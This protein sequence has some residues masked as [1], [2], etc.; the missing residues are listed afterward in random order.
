ME[1]P[2]HDGAW[3]YAYDT[4]HEMVAAFHAARRDAVATEIDG[5][6]TTPGAGEWLAAMAYARNV[7]CGLGHGHGLGLSDTE[8]V[9]AIR[10]LCIAAAYQCKSQVADHAT[11]AK[12]T[13]YDTIGYVH[14]HQLLSLAYYRPTSYDSTIELDRNYFARWTSQCKAA[15]DK[16][17]KQYGNSDWARHAANAAA[18]LIEGR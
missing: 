16:V 14:Y 11:F 18:W 2:Q 10:N 9:T 15:I 7:L 1:R 6:P 4:R 8:I 17:V 13:P 12:Y 5:Y 3:T